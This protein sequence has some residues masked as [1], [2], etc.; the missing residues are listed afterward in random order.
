MTMHN[1]N[2][3]QIENPHALG[4]QEALE[5]LRVTPEGLKRE[6]AA[7]RLRSV[8]PNR[9]PEPP[10]EGV[11]KRFFKHFHDL[12]IYILI[13]AAFITA[14]LGHFVDTGVILAVV[15]INAIIGFLQE[16]KAEEALEGIRKMLSLTAHV[17]RGGEWEETGAEELVPGDIVRLRSGDRVPADVR[18]LE[19]VNLRIEEAALTGES[20]PSEKDTEAVSSGAGVG[21]RSCM[22]YSGTMV[23]A[24]RGTGV[25]TATGASTEI[26]KI[27]RMI[28]DVKQLATPLTRQMNRFGKV[29]SVVVV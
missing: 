12:L 25:V 18:L 4:A 13:A 24:G 19:M 5:Q 1:E 2:T 11:L 6:D 10:K 3:F 15:V 8:G 20:V 21:D 28:S 23:T 16:G 17:R 9:L 27:N 22:A 26:G 14:V 7:G 29:L